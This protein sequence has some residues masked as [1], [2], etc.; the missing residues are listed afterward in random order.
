M[1]ELQTVENVIWS[2]ITPT[3]ISHTHLALSIHGDNNHADNSIPLLLI[4]NTEQ[5]SLCYNFK[6]EKTKVE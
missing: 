3:M 5:G 4:N 6:D 2:G 1:Y